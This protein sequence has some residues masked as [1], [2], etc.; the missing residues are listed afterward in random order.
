[1]HKYYFISIGV[2]CNADS[3]RDMEGKEHCQTWWLDGEICCVKCNFLSYCCV[4][5]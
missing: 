1:M 2:A 4:V 3:K 5:F